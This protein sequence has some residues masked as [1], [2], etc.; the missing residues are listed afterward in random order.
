MPE[1]NSPLSATD[2]L[3]A[4]KCLARTKWNVITQWIFLKASG[5]CLI[6]PPSSPQIIWNVVLCVS[7]Q[8]ASLHTSPQHDLNTIS[9]FSSQVWKF[10]LYEESL[11]LMESLHIYHPLHPDNRRWD[12]GGRV[13]VD[14]HIPQLL[15]DVTMIHSWYCGWAVCWNIRTV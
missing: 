12:D 13:Q 5:S 14:H 8:S 6:Y 4:D 9:L 2:L 11:H 10:D 15:L 1:I 7:V 3:S